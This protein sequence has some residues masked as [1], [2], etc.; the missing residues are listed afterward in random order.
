LTPEAL[1]EFTR[2]FA[3]DFSTSAGARAEASGDE[4]DMSE[5]LPEAVVWPLETEDVLLLVEAC[6]KHKLPLTMR[7]GGTGLAGSAIPVRGGLVVDTTRMSKIVAVRPA[8]LSVTVQPGVRLDQ[9]NKKLA[10]AG[11][12]LPASVG[13]AT[14]GA[15]IGGMVATAASGP[16]SLKY[17]PIRRRVLGLTAVTGLGEV[18]RTGNRCPEAAAGYDLTGLLVGSEGT[19]AVITELTL[20]VEGVPDL[21]REVMWSFA[22]LD[23]MAEAV[24]ML[25]REGVDLAACEL[26]D[27]RSADALNA[28]EGS[29]LP[30]QPLLITAVEGAES[31]VPAAD[32]QVRAICEAHGA[33][34][35]DV[36]EPLALRHKIHGAARACHPGTL[37]VW[38]DASF[39]LGELGNVVRL[40]AQLGEKHDLH[41]YTFGAVG[42]GII[43][44]VI[45]ARPDDFVAWDVA[46]DVQEEVLDYVM[47]R[48]GSCAAWG[49]V[50]LTRRPF[51]TR[52]HGMALEVMRRL[53]TAFD[54]EGVLNPGKVLP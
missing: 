3:E 35:V 21:R 17:G 50:G 34:P 2:I 47:D 26:L 16:E 43:N 27:A 24:G 39:P 46:A 45:Q 15:T 7:G 44:I 49:G 36:A 9:L 29:S 6:R 25:R 10:K 33:T 37:T 32:A 4:S 1:A 5:S 41:L 11:L 20:A 18:I 8:D 12:W 38:S 51:I 42:A 14:G 53:K 30:N 23:S 48:G 13:A 19:L 31:A 52:E 22:D 28:V 54:P 40:L